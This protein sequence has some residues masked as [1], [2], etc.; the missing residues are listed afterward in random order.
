[1]LRIEQHKSA[2]GVGY[3]F[4]SNYTPEELL[5]RI[6]DAIDASMTLESDPTIWAFRDD[7][8]FK[9]TITVERD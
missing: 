1:M 9:I 8:R 3:Y 7:Q 2:S 6:D 5:S 4:S